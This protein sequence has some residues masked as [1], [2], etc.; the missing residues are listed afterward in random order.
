MTKINNTRNR[1]ANCVSSMALLVV[2]TL[3]GNASAQLLDNTLSSPFIYLDNQGVTT[4]DA[5]S[6]KFV[7]DASPL[8]LEIDSF[9]AADFASGGSLVIDIAVDNTGGLSGGV[10]GPD[11]IVT[12][13]VDVPGVG[14]VTGT[15]LTG[16][17]T[18][19]GF[20]NSSGST[21]RFDFTFNLTGGQLLDLYPSETVGIAIVSESSNFNNLFTVNFGG[22][23]KGTLGSIP[24]QLAALGDRVWE[25]L[26]ADGVQ[27]CADSN[28]NGKLGD[29]L[30]DPADP[31]VSDQGTECGAGVQDVI[32]KLFKLDTTV[33]AR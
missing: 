21:D 19:F 2:L 1:L 12:G 13:T 23:A 31:A 33:F 17:V 9:P 6:K 22:E 14:I 26:D 20:F 27:D 10:S 24:G 7:V 16:E 30:G 11:L 15:L 8:A 4:Y 32:V 5:T 3:S 25:D 28:G 29:I 18:G